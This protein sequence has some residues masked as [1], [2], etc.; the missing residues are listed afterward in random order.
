MTGM[1]EMLV[2][3]KIEDEL[4]CLPSSS[5]PRVILLDPDHWERFIYEINT[6][7]GL[8]NSEVRCGYVSECDMA[9]RNGIPISKVYEFTCPNL[10]LIFR[11]NEHIQC[12]RIIS[13][14]KRARRVT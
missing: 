14:I 13:Q 12:I 1:S 8:A 9:E 11:R 5:R 4:R 6:V 10:R 3:S 2:A 7:T